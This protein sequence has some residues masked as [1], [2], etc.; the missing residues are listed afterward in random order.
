MKVLIPV[1]QSAGSMGAVKA[2]SQCLSQGDHDYTLLH[3]TETL[4]AYVVAQAR[5]GGNIYA[6]VVEEWTDAKRKL[7]EDL[8]SS[9]QAI[10]T[11]AGIPETRITQKLETVQ[12]L[13]EAKR[14]A[15]ARAIID[16][17]KSDNYELVVI[18][19]REDSNVLPFVGSVSQAVLNEGTG[20][21]IWIVDGVN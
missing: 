17:M 6:T 21:T 18:G 7:G 19:R 20:R 12:A 1:N 13:P 11:D 14:V 3:V 16:V 15:D 2:V 10:M 4:P 5:N 9:C 8:L